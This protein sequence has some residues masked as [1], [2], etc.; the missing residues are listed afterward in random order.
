M[1]DAVTITGLR[2]AFGGLTVLDGVDL[3]VAAGATTAIIGP[4]GCGKSTLLRILAGL[5]TPTSGEVVIGGRTVTGRTGH[6]AYMP[7]ADGLLPWRR[8]LANA[9][10][11]AEITGGDRTRTRMR[12]EDLFARFGLAGFERSWPAELSGGMR[13]R[14]A[15]LRTILTGQ[16]VLLLDEPFGALDAMTRADLHD[17]LGELLRAEP[18]T[19]LLVTHDIDDALRLADTIVVL[20]SRP[21]RPLLTVPVPGSRPRDALRLTETDMAETKRR[22]LTAMGARTARSAVTAA[23]G[24]AARRDD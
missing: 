12:A 5:V 1:T 3:S 9:T 2:H 18:R 10:L 7:Q 20:S 15:F 14:V 13:Q 22:V 21:G 8:A 23:D 11:A 6:A 17:W 16:G 24:E 19:A 4:S